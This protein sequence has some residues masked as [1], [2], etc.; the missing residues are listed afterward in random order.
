MTLAENLKEMD[1]KTVIFDAEL[2]PRQQK[3]IENK[4]NGP[5]PDLWGECPVKV[6]DRTAL[7]LDI[8]AQHA[9]T[10]EGK[11]QVTLAME[12]YRAPRLT[13]LW[14]HLERQSGAGGVGLRGP[15]ESQLEIDKRL[16]RDRIHTLQKKIDS[17]SRHRNLQRK[18]REN[19]G[20]P[21]ISLI[22]YTNAG[23]SSL[24]NKL[25]SARVLAEDILFA[26]LDPTTRSVKLPGLKTHPEVILTD[27]VGFIQKVST[28][29]SS[30]FRLR[31]SEV[32]ARNCVARQRFPMQ[33]L[34]QY[35]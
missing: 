16:L 10:R 31:R 1:V 30:A 26:T 11:L 9:K 8:F 18:S 20:T 17:I 5:D 2:S 24:L 29:K 33:H 22:G 19:L 25:T 13:K 35:F 15:G 12:S 32:R 23:K 3:A 14:S 7:I 21:L 4:L 27:T 28:A 6:V 34:K